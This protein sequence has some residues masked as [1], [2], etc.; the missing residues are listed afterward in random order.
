VVAN[1][2]RAAYSVAL[3]AT[4][5]S[6]RHPLTVGRAWPTVYPMNKFTATIEILNGQNAAIVSLFDFSGEWSGGG[7]IELPRAPAHQVEDALY[8]QGYI[9]ASRS[10]ASK[11]GTLESYRRVA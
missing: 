4:E 10:A 11:N 1:F 3:D 9:T 6:L 2:G 7:R 8:E 5:K